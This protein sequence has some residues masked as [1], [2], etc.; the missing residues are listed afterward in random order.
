MTTWPDVADD[1]LIVIL[2]LGLAAILAWYKR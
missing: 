1:A 2:I